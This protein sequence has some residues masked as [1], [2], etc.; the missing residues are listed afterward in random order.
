VLREFD[1]YADPERVV[2]SLSDVGFPVEHVIV[3][4][5]I[6]TVARVTGSMAT[7]RATLDGAGSGALM[8]RG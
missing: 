8:G 1:D 4:T 7:G 2:D 3:G 6:R 5:G